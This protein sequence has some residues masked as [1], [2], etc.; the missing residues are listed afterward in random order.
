MTEAMNEEALLEEIPEL[1][2]PPALEAEAA[3][4]ESNAEEAAEVAVAD[5]L[6]EGETPEDEAIEVNPEV[7]VAI[8]EDELPPMA[9]VELVAEPV[10]EEDEFP[11]ELDL[12]EEFVV[13]ESAED[14]GESAIRIL[15]PDETT[16]DAA[17]AEIANAEA[18]PDA[19]EE[20][21]TATHEELKPAIESLL[22][23]SDEPLPFK[24]LCK[25]LGE[26][27]E[28]DVLTALNE[29]AAD[30]DAR[31]SGLEIRE[32][33]GGWR[34]STRPQN[35]EFIRKYLKSRPSARLSLPAL[36]TLAVI[37]YKQPITIPEILEIRGVSSSSAIKTLLE[38]RLI[39]TKGRKE[40]VGKPMM[41]GTSK[42][43]LIQ[44]GLKDLNELPSIED[45][46]D[47]AQ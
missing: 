42:E 24:Q 38:K 18:A 3:A 30:Y 46:E 28:Q 11:S 2:E 29:L 17:N 1:P 22:F 33:A 40:T 41:Y 15:I 47:L 10:P 45:F 5:S 19:A 13:A 6:P 8:V 39:V 35:H 37:A 34:I 31:S 32:I 25:I 21:I 43:F 9:V 16:P 44:F 4:F 14:I 7:G 27:S 23:V 20:A 26:I 36:E 12:G